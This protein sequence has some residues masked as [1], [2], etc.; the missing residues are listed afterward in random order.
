MIRKFFAPVISNTPLT[1]PGHFVL[2]FEAPELARDSRPGQFVAVAAD[3]GTQV[4]RRP[5]SV[6]T[7]DPEN[8]TASILF[9]VYGPT[10]RALSRYEPGDR[11]DMIGPLGGS[12]FIADPRPDAHHV[13]VGGGYGVP[14]LAF[15]S[16]TIRAENPE[17]SI[18]FIVGARTQNLLVG[19][20]GLEDIGARL[21][22]C[23]NDGSFGYKGMVTGQLEELLE[24]EPGAY[25]F[26]SCGPTPMMKAVAQVAI[27]RDIPCQVS[28]EPFMPCGIGICMGCAIPLPDG[29]YARGCTEGPVFEAREVVW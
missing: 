7:V 16:R 22:C 11:I 23:T 24:S 13:M 28:L 29:S 25:H 5:F 3:T 20:D 9:S 27:A 17:A 26:Y 10:T 8:G 14:P 18:S 2:E 19:M 12:G 1:A 15:L 6:Y 21:L 4:L